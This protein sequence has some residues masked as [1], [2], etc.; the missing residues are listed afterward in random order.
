MK[1]KYYKVVKNNDGSLWS[2][3]C[4]EVLYK[5]GQWVV[6]P[7]NTRLFVFDDKHEAIMF[8]DE[9]EGEEV[10]GCDIIGGIKFFGSNFSPDN[11][12]F[13]SIW[14]EFLSKKKKFDPEKVKK[15]LEKKE[16]YLTSYPAVLAKK[17]KLTKLIKRK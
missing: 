9:G 15:V 7:Q 13:W 10:Y 12:D 4:G 3:R 16:I 1:K 6:A 14:N 5:V 8:A 2:A 11:D 17:V